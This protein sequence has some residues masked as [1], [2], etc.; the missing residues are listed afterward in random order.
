MSWK[1]WLFGA[2]GMGVWDENGRSSDEKL[3]YAVGDIHGRADLLDQLVGE[4][5]RDR[6]EAGTDGEGAAIVF[7]G[8]YIDR[9]R[10]SNDVI[11]RLN[12]GQFDGFE[13]RFLMGNH[14]E[15]LLEFLHDP[16]I[17]PHWSSFGGRET[18]ASYGVD[19]PEQDSDEDGWAA[20]QADFVK[21]FPEDHRLFLEEKL[22]LYAVYGDYM[23]VHAGVRP[24][25]PLD[26][27]VAR[28]LLWI[29]DDFLEDARPLERVIVHGHTPHESPYVDERRIS[30][31]TGAYI[32]GMLSAARI[33]NN[34]IR[35]LHT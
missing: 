29:R 33:H 4:I 25:R 28:D 34:D 2:P 27:Q 19:G 24:S 8:D 10:R 32:S 17:G 9:G 14:E 7:L 13:V 5:A 1:T 23:F 3:I 11:S 6:D 20:T 26:M 22:E 30:V 35:F 16:G 12:G 15:A 31:D 18:L 21:A